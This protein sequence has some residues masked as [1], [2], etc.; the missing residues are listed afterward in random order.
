MGDFTYG[1]AVPL[2]GVLG[3]TTTGGRRFIAGR[4]VSGGKELKCIKETINPHKSHLN[5]ESGLRYL[6]LLRQRQST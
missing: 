3:Q 2:R 5:A 1:G 6:L 4:R